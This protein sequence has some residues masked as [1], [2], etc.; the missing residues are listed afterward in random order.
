MLLSC[1]F[2]G[3]PQKEVDLTSSL[4]DT[5]PSDEVN[6]N[7]KS[8][9][10]KAEFAAEERNFH[11][12]VL[13]KLKYDGSTFNE[14]SEDG[15]VN[16]FRISK[17]L[18]NTYLIGE[19]EPMYVERNEEKKESFVKIYAYETKNLIYKNGSPIMEIPEVRLSIVEVSPNVFGE[20]YARVKVYS[21]ELV[22]HSDMKKNFEL[23]S[24]KSIFKGIEENEDIL[25]I[26]TEKTD[27][28]ISNYNEM[29][30]TSGIYNI[31]TYEDFKNLDKSKFKKIDDLE[32][33]NGVFNYSH[34]INIKDFVS[35]NSPLDDAAEWDENSQ[36]LI[37]DLNF[38]EFRY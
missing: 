29:I 9:T 25:D 8:E 35:S 2:S 13:R 3:E 21:P 14:T 38:I 36:R 6:T 10:E 23:I 28:W 11:L 27:K 37:W 26:D 34:V 24:G 22:G 7:E 31:N 1:N 30:R 12:E 18:I 16:N 20:L 5:N 15:T 19:M 17:Q 32:S 4:E 33:S